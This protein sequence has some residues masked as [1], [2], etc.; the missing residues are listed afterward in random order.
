MSA[1]TRDLLT[2]TMIVK[3]EASNLAATLASIKPHIDRW[4]IADTGSTDGTPEVIRAAMEGVPGELVEI[5]FVNFAATRNAGLDACGEH[6]EF[7]LWLD[8]EDVVQQGAALRRFLERERKQRGPEHEAYYLRVDAGFAWNSP[9]VFRSKARWRF[10]GVVHE[11]LTHD[12]RVAPTIRVPEVVIAHNRA[13]HSIERTRRRWERDRLLLEGELA[14]NP[15]DTRAAFYLAQT[16]ACLGQI[17]PAINAYQQRIALGG[18]REEVYESKYQV[19]LLS[20]QAGRPWPEVLALYLDA[21]AFAPHRA[22]P[23][24]QIALHHNLRGEHALAVLY[25]RRGLDLPVPEQDQL[26]VLEEVYRWKL[27][28][29]MGASAFWVGEMEMGEAAARK[30]VRARPDDQ[31]LQRNLTFYLERKKKPRRR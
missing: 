16:H 30:A 23:L 18:W 7:I 21:H 31:R 27:A 1:R 3:D 13:E 26:F 4:V 25:A 29:L 20:E 5:P 28:D 24:Y 2:L 17:E 9:R 22:E 10:R 12:D 8:A 6:T 11:I 19:A 15:G 14:K